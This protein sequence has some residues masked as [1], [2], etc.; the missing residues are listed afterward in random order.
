MW[1]DRL[2][3]VCEATT[4]P[5]YFLWGTEHED[6]AIV[7]IRNLQKAVQPYEMN[8]PWGPA[9]A[10]N[11][12]FSQSQTNSLVQFLVPRSTK[13][14][15]NVETKSVASADS[16][17]AIHV[18]STSE[19]SSATVSKAQASSVVTR[20]LAINELAQPN[21]GNDLLSS[22]KKRASGA[23]RQPAK[24]KPTNSIARFFLKQKTS[25]Q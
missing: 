5:V 24:K 3:A 22:P 20:P 12:F 18:F 15:P 11:K 6:Q 10:I 1:V 7:N 14:I 21:I 16:A 25:Q 8:A 4:G 17:T 9:G 23:Q 19:D 2:R 13:V